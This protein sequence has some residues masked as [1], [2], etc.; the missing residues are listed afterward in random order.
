MY[1]RWRYYISLSGYVLKKV[2]GPEA[3][4]DCLRA[5]FIPLDQL[6]VE[7]APYMVFTSWRVLYYKLEDVVVVVVVVDGG[8]DYGSF[9]ELSN[10]KKKDDV[11]KGVGLC[12]KVCE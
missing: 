2:D 1:K 12:I 8:G 6:M 7:T 3:V 11:A 9:Q 5:G 10:K 4:G